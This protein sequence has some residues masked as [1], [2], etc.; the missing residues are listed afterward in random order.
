MQDFWTHLHALLSSVF[1]ILNL[2]STVLGL[3]LP[4]G[5]VGAP[6]A[7]VYELAVG[8]LNVVFTSWDTYLD[9]SYWQDILQVMYC[10]CPANGL[11][12]STA[13]GRI[14]ADLAD[15]ETED[16]PFY[17]LTKLLVGIVGSHG[18][19]NCGQVYHSSGGNCGNFNCSETLEYHL[20]SGQNGWEKWDCGNQAYQG[21]WE[22]GTGFR[23]TYSTGRL[24]GTA[25]GAV[26]HTTLPDG[27]VATG[28]RI[29]GHNGGPDDSMVAWG[30]FWS[31][32]NNYVWQQQSFVSGQAFDVT[33]TF[34]ENVS[35]NLGVISRNGHIKAYSSPPGFISAIYVYGFYQ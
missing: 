12:T 14:Q 11:Y 29:I 32:C 17:H 23:Y 24:T 31:D 20:T 30:S 9:N 19:N 35:G 21:E 3:F 16:N 2:T 4:I 22:N 1:S 7:L 27:F 13:V 33:V 28:A 25:Y 5:V 10:N 18:L 34:D 8:V 26:I 15:L 6:A